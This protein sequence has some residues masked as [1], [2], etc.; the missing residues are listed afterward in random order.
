MYH[1][2][3]HIYW[4]WQRSCDTIAEYE[5]SRADQEIPLDTERKDR[6]MN[7]NSTT[8]TKQET[9][10]GSQNSRGIICDNV[11]GNQTAFCILRRG[12]F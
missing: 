9:S 3:C 10:R 2:S 12:N 4:N 7:D 6:T 5:S 8:V 1:F 11:R